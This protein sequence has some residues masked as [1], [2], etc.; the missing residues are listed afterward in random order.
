M[1]VLHTRRALATLAPLD[2]LGSALPTHRER[3]L[4]R[5]RPRPSPMPNHGLTPL[6]LVRHSSWSMRVLQPR[7]AL[8]TLAPPDVLALASPTHR[9]RRLE[10]ARPRP[11]PL[12]NP[13]SVEK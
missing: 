5:A 7:L 9:S 2:A 8:K 4:E 10:F 12:P 1:R 6:Q 13:V 3:P 11:P